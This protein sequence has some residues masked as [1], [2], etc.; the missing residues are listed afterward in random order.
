MNLRF[1]SSLCLSIALS[2]ISACTSH[3]DRIGL[4][5]VRLTT[6]TIPTDVLC[7]SLT[8]EG[9]TTTVRNFDV[10]PNQTP[11]LTATGLP[12]GSVTLTESAYNVSCSQ[13]TTT[14]PP[15]WI[16]DSPVVVELIPGQTVSATIVL[17]R[18][19]KVVVT[20]TF[21]DNVDGGVV[22]DGGRQDVPPLLDV[23]KSDVLGV[24]D[25]GGRTVGTGPCDIY[26]AANMPCGA[27][28]SMVRTL[29][30]KYS[31]PLYQV[32]SG[33]STTNTGTGG[34]TKDIGM[35]SDGYAD[36][37]AQDTF[38][39]GTICTVSKLYDQSGNGNDLQR[40]SAGPSGN[41]TRSGYDDYESS[42]TKLSI[43]AGGHKVYALYMAQY[44]GYRTALNVTG[45]GL[46]TG[47]KDQGIYELADGTHFGKTCC[48][49]F[50]SAS[51]DP[52]KYVTTNTLFFG[53]GYWGSGTGSGPWFGGISRAACGWGALQQRQETTQA[54]CPWALLSPSAF[55]THPSGNM[56]L[57][58]PMCRLPPI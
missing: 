27:A 36:S 8:A 31:G 43:T 20:T 40:G 34:T 29:S 24:P 21:V 52:N 37:A 46:P 18:A 44:E 16:S 53:T 48:W 45:K 28:Y 23:S 49:D 35:L 12:T 11:T 2:G 55:S 4:G 54:A 38:C 42:A 1:A 58:W 26:A 32:R 56:L 14:T 5:I 47:N 15:D 30:S 10:A 33:S 19:G 3:D 6:T 39:T 25:A 22:E 13:V 7:L 57:G 51:P 9:L 50:G 17:R 41:G